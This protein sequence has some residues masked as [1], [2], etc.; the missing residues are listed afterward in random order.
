MF[1]NT[2]TQSQGLFKDFLGFAQHFS[3]SPGLYC[4]LD[5]KLGENYFNFQTG[6]HGNFP[7]TWKSPSYYRRDQ[8]KRKPPGKGVSTPGN[9]NRFCS[10]WKPYRS[11]ERKNFIG[12][13][14]YSLQ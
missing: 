3:Q 11:T 8:R 9:Q 4:R 12:T 6:S 14:L 2:S 13:I 10:S 1:P 7:G 5:V